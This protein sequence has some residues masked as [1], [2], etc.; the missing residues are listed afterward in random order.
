MGVGKKEKT[1]L[2]TKNI[3]RETVSRWLFTCRQQCGET[4]ILAGNDGDPANSCQQRLWTHLTADINLYQ[5]LRI[6]VV[7]LYLSF[8]LWTTC[9]VVGRLFFENSFTEKFF[10]TAINRSRICCAYLSRMSKPQKL[11]Y[12]F[13]QQQTT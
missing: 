1:K 2:H 10:L 6:W 12:G 5:Q 11:D 9:L 4:C 3:I 8:C 7:C 13:F